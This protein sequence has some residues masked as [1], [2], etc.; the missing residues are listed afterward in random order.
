MNKYRNK[1]TYL[2]GRKFDSKK[3]SLRYLV[4]KDRLDR[5]EI[6]DLRMQVP[7]ELIPAIYEE[8][9]KHLKTK[10][11]IEKKCIQRAVKYVADFVYYDNVKGEEVIEDVKGGKAGITKEFI[12]KKKL[13]RYLSGKDITIV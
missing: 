9:V 7:Y 1:I 11:K 10:D 12:L 5:G 6:R 4:L 3:E 2:Y 13:L 8:E